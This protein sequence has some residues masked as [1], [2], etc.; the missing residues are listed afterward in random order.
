MDFRGIAMNRGFDDSPYRYLSDESKGH[1]CYR[2]PVNDHTEEFASSLRRQF[3]NKAQEMGY[4]GYDTDYDESFH[5]RSSYFYVRNERING[6]PVFLN[7]RV[8]DAD[9]SLPFPFETGECLGGSSYVLHERSKI[10]DLNT[11][12]GLGA[13]WLS[14]FHLIASAVGLFA[15]KNSCYR[16][17]S[18]VD[19]EKHDVEKLYKKYAKFWSSQE[20]PEPIFF[21]GYT[22]VNNKSKKPVNVHW[23]ILE[24]GKREID[25]HAL[26]AQKYKFEGNN[27][28]N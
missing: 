3:I 28:T 7:T 12:F 27:D 9:Q 16:A 8:T 25:Q 18:L 1:V 13:K 22:S 15:K 4:R 19:V 24:W 21:P 26:A 17:F 2:L 10:L 6:S 14:G 23:G 20:F 11:F 5:R